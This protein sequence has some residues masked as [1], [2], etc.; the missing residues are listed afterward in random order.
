LPGISVFQSLDLGGDFKCARL[1]PGI[2]PT[3]PEDHR[4]EAEA[5]IGKGLTQSQTFSQF[6][7]LNRCRQSLKDSTRYQNVSTLENGF[8]LDERLPTSEG[9]G[10]HRHFAPV[11]DLDGLE[12]R[13]DR[14]AP[15]Q[16]LDL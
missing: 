12:P 9:R 10:S 6:V 7:I 4:L 2:D 11:T 15:N 3:P 14:V 8:D 13:T 16:P 5:S 1:D